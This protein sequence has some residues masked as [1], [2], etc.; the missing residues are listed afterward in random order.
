[1]KTKE[2]LALENLI[3]DSTHKQGVFCCFEVTIGWYGKE[4]VDYMTYDTNGI[5]RCY[6]LK[7]TKADFHSSCHTSFVGH[8]NYYVMPESLYEQV[9]DE[10]PDGVGAYIQKGNFLVSARRAKRQGVESETLDILK[11]SLIR[12]LAREADKKRTSESADA[13]SR[14]KRQLS[15]IEREKDQLRRKYWD[16]LSEMEELYGRRWRHPPGGVETGER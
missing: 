3:Y 7:V 12:S 9:K 15:Q 14:L 1:M 10:I 16:L 5:F 8:Y 6:E 11:N 13:M 2:T 4:R